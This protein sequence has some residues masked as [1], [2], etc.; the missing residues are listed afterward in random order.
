[1]EN[2]EPEHSSALDLFSSSCVVSALNQKSTDE[3][4]L[5]LTNES[6]MSIVQRNGQRI[7]GGP[8]PDWKGPAPEKG[9]EIFCGKVPRDCFEDELVPIFTKVDNDNIDIRAC[10]G[11]LCMMCDYLVQVGEIYELR[12]MMDFSGSNRGFCFVR[13]T[14]RED[15][16]RAVKD[17]NNF[18]IRPNKFLGIL[19]SVDNRKLWIS[20]IPRNLTSDQIMASYRSKLRIYMYRRFTK[21]WALG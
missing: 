2:G 3:R 4:L 10:V 20:G 16:K 19:H 11:Q 13:Y 15:A 8:P 14:T 21:R 1:M 17:L 7:Y 5:D 6:G 9:C 12:L 18:E